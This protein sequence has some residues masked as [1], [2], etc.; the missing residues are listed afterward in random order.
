MKVY[1]ISWPTFNG[2]TEYKD[3]KVLHLKATKTFQ[4]DYVRESLITIGS[5]TG[6]H[7]DA[8][9]HFLKE[10]KSIEEIGPLSCVGPAQ[11]IDMTHV[12]TCIDAEEINKIEIKPN[13]LVLF[14]TKNSQLQVNAPFNHDFIYLNAE[15]AK[16]LVEKEARAVGIDYLGIER[17]QPNHETHTTLLEKN[18]PII[19]GLRL[20]HVNAGNYFM[21]CL[22]LSIPGIDAVPARAVLIEE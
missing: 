4:K 3:R 1:D 11:V 14:K 13:M 22:P 19:E 21:W 8:P 6:T 5:H 18:I 2:M 10:G 7:I 15:G 20:A 17:Q 16:A 9:A 12:E